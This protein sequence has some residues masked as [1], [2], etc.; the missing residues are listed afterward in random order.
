M[1]K[2]KINN[3][4]TLIISHS[5]YLIKSGGL[6]KFIRDYCQI[7]KKYNIHYI[8]IFPI[9]EINKK[10][11]RFGK[12]FVGISLDENFLGIWGVD[13]IAD[14]VDELLKEKSYRLANC[15]VHHFHGWNTKKLSNELKQLNVPI[16]FMVHDLKS[17]AP[18]MN[19]FGFEK[20]CKTEVPIAGSKEICVNCVDCVDEYRQV[21]YAFR[22]LSSL[23]RGVYTPSENTKN[24]FNQAFP[25][26]KNVTHV[27]GHLTYEMIQV[28]RKINN[29][30]RIAY[31]GSIAEHKGYLE[32]EK[33]TASL[34]TDNYSFYYFG[35]TEIKDDRIETVK[36]DA[37]NPKLR[38]MIEQLQEYNID[39][40]FLWS[41]WPETYCYTYYEAFEAGCFVITSSTSGNIYDEVMKYQ[42]GKIFNNISD[43]I[44][45]LYNDNL[46]RETLEKFK[47]CGQRPKDVRTNDTLIGNVSDYSCENNYVLVNK[48]K[49][50]KRRIGRS[51]FISLIYKI[52]RM[53]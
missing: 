28:E 43:C 17:I 48:N 33:L 20:L 19:R 41:K 36:V 25:E 44:E 27:R 38:S 53:N 5:N 47:K 11:Q 51:H 13:R 29:P 16:Y 18:C 23:I 52:M 4:C 6:E 26:F 31:L 2:T 9:I 12:E 45:Y 32:W 30:I 35:V 50:K 3:N 15:Q 42:N 37:R 10:T 7:L 21:I 34:P 14:K 1:N 46:T 40:A 49:I 8:H 24:Y 39:I 22:E